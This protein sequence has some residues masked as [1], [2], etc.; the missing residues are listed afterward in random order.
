MAN[1]LRRQNLSDAEAL[2]AVS[3]FDT[4]GRF[5]AAATNAANDEIFN[6]SNTVFVAGVKDSVAT[7]AAQ[8]AAKARVLKGRNH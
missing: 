2:N 4:L 5:D 6:S 7:L 1:I 3:V 8:A